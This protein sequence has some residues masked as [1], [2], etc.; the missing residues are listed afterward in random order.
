MHKELFRAVFRS[1]SSISFAVTYWDGE[2]EVYGPKELK[3]LPFRIIFN[4][5]LNLREML[6]DP[7]TRFGQ[8]YMDQQI[9]VEGDFSA[10]LSLLLRN[11]D[12]FKSTERDGLFQRLMKSRSSESTDKQSEN[13]ETEY[14]LGSD[15]F[16]LWLDSTLSYSCAYFRTPEDTL[17]QAQLQKIDHILNK[18]HLKEGETL[19]D[20]GSGWGWLI[21]RAARKYGVKALGITLR[22]EEEEKTRK[23]IEHEGLEEQVEVRL[24]DYR[25]LA[26]E[27]QTFDKIVSVG[28]FKY[29]GKE[30]IPTYFR[31]LQKMLKPQ[32]LSLLH[33]ITRSLE[34]PTATWLEKY[35][36]PRG[37]IPSLREIIWLLPEFSFHL[38]DAESLRMHYA[39]TTTRWAENF[40]RVVDKVR[41]KYGERFVR[42]WRL[43]LLGC[44][45]SFMCSGLDVHQLLFSR[46]ICND[47]PLVRE[48]IGC[49]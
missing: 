22:E 13:V 48:S 40:E 9:D 10:L 37:Y 17:D 39:L 19:L 38:V 35:I 41:E 49:R 25:D 45:N 32:G 29:V 42:M 14:N 18:L 8:A 3:D 47:L 36:Y 34:S 20:I 1:I 11:V 5:P 15:F 46:G 26:V 28:M 23:R 44:S 7:E 33:T 2:T 6:E 27:N 24:A 30:N 43:Y 4:E 16:K 21:I 12:V 31:C